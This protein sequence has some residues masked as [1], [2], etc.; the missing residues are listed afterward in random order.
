MTWKF[1]LGVS[2]GFAAGYGVARAMDQ[3]AKQAAIAAQARAGEVGGGIQVTPAPR[4]LP[5]V[6]YAAPP[7]AEQNSSSPIDGLEEVGLDEYN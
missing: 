1:W 2:A 5:P 6:S 7:P 4:A 3:R